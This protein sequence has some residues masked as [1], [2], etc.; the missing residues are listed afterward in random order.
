MKKAIYVAVLLAGSASLSW[1]QTKT[2]VVSHVSSGSFSQ[3]NAA[4]NTPT[5]TF[6]VELRKS[7]EQINKDTK[8]GKLSK[9]QAQTARAQ[10]KGIRIQELQFFKENG[11][12]QLTSEQLTQLDQSL[13][14]LSSSL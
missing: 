9:T 1:A 13:S 14:Q 10:V 12:K 8:S 4:I 2:P 7:M 3:G 6:N 5:H 11:N